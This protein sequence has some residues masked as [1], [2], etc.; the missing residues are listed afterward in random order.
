[1]QRNCVLIKNHK[2]ILLYSAPS[3]V[4]RVFQQKPLR[5]F[6]KDRMIFFKTVLEF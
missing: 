2:G 4:Y 5:I 3:S 1:M 6:R